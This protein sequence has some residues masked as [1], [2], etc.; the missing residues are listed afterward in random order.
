MP[1][2]TEAYL[3]EFILH[4]T[5]PTR[6]PELSPRQWSSDWDAKMQYSDNRMNN[7]VLSVIC[8][9]ETA[10]NILWYVQNA[11][12]KFEY[13]SVYIYR[14]DVSGIHIPQLP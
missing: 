1:S 4:P 10:L 5:S 12:K 7:V 11:K 6:P 9:L 8:V 14:L 13:I 3:E 2:E